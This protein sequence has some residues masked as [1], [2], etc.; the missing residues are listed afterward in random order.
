MIQAQFFI[1]TEL[2]WQAQIEVSQPLPTHHL[3][4]QAGPEL[5]PA[6]LKGGLSK[7]SA[8]VESLFSIHLMPPL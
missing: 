5:S 1:R 2:K 8:S 7:K 6:M 3:H 4:V